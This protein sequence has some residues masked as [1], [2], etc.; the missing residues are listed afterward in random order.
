[1]TGQSHGR[2]APIGHSCIVAA[3]KEIAMSRSVLRVHCVWVLGTLLVLSACAM[4]G[5]VK[6]SDAGGQ[7]KAAAPVTGWDRSKMG[8]LP[9]PKD[10][11]LSPF[12]GQN[13]GRVSVGFT[14]AE[15]A[16]KAYVQILKDAGYAKKKEGTLDGDFEYVGFKEGSTVTVRFRQRT[17][18]GSIDFRPFDVNAGAPWPRDY[19]ADLPRPAAPL[20]NVE[21]AGG[22]VTMST[23][24][25]SE[26]TF[27]AYA[28][29]CRQAGYSNNWQEHMQGSERYFQGE[30]KRGD[31]IRVEHMDDTVVSIPSANISLNRKG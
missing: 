3:L 24:Y 12:T 14:A 31:M 23:G 16:V 29:A 4:A 21:E 25:M 26:A 28:D 1:M 13:K 8:D 20:Y 11:E 10:L 18:A 17:S 15:G 6:K 2:K 7:K 27:K 5:E 19:L 22:Y 9:E 30:N